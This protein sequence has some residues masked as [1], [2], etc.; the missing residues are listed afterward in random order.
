[1]AYNLEVRGSD[2]RQTIGDCVVEVSLEAY[3]RSTPLNEPKASL[4]SY[5]SGPVTGLPHQCP[6]GLSVAAFAQI[7]LGCPVRCTRR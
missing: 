4:T 1:M 2:L 6:L 5:G 3:P 7:E